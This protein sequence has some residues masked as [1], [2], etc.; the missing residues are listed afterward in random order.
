MA[1]LNKVLLIGNLGADPEVRVTGTGQSVATI[2]L[3]TTDRWVDKSGQK[4]ERT[5]WHRV[6]AWGKQAEL[7]K[8]YLSKGRQI[9]VE[10]RIQTREWNDKEGNK[11]YT[12]EVVAQRIQFLG[13]PAGKQARTES[14]TSDAPPFNDTSSPLFPLDD[15]SATGADSDI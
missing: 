12:T 14:G 9:Y 8:E 5:E 1:S 11:R 3:A 2:R 13:S 4:T 10:G 15:A 6:I 7:C